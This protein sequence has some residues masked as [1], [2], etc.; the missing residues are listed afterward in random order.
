LGCT[1]AVFASRY[2]CLMLRILPD[3]RE[4][5]YCVSSFTLPIWQPWVRVFVA[6]LA[7]VPLALSIALAY[8]L[9]LT[10]W[11]YAMTERISF[12]AF[13][14]RIPT[15][16]LLGRCAIVAAIALLGDASRLLLASLLLPGPSF[17]SPICFLLLPSRFLPL[18]SPPTPLSLTVP[19]RG[20]AGCATSQLHELSLSCSLPRRHCALPVTGI[21]STLTCLH[22]PPRYPHSRA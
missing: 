1:R 3:G 14:P 4:V 11:P 21:F 6:L 2:A 22:F 20:L 9:G 13:S 5:D 8:F 16:V 15:I 19:A 18:F 7:I 17:L 12:G 10:A